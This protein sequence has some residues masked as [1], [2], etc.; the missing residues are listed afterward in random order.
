MHEPPAGVWATMV[1]PFTDGGAI[2]YPGL[3]SL[4]DWYIDNR[5]AGLFAVCRSSESFEMS[6]EERRAVAAFVVGTTAGR[7]PVIAGGNL[8]E[9][10]EAQAD[11]VAMIAATG[12]DGVVLLT[13]TMAERE[14]GDV[15]WCRRAEALLARIPE[16]IPLGIYESPAPYHRT[17]GAEGL[18]WCLETG[19]FRFLKDTSCD[20][21]A[22]SE[23]LRILAG[24]NLRLYNA[25]TQTLLPSLRYGAAGYSSVM[26]NVSPRLYD[27]L[28][29]NHHS[30]TDRAERLVAFLSVADAALVARCY[31][32]SAKYYLRLEGLPISTYT[33]EQTRLQLDSTARITMEHLRRVV[34]EYEASYGT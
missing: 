1:T 25:N 7:V 32:A 10:A 8:T 15:A 13:S 14:E 21:G 27:W 28:I 9:G 16:G 34:K 33:R 23:K 2:D 26:A 18:S 12:V 30:H 6:L 20:A 5:V 3:A 17:V 11:E 29:T 24:S 4:V 19:R 22:L 31:P